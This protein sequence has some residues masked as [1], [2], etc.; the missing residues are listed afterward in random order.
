MGIFQNLIISASSFQTNMESQSQMRQE[1]IQSLNPYEYHHE[2]SDS[3]ERG[4]IKQEFHDKIFHACVNDIKEEKDDENYY[5]NS[6]YPYQELETNPLE[7]ETNG[8]K[9][10]RESSDLIPKSEIKSEEFDDYEDYGND[11]AY[12]F[13]QENY[14]KGYEITKPFICAIC[15]ARFTAK[16]SLNT[17]MASVHEGKKHYCD[18][19]GANFNHRQSLKGHIASVHEG[20]KPFICMVCQK[21]FAAGKSLRYHMAAFHEGGVKKPHKCSWCAIAFH[22]KYKLSEHIDSVHEGKRPFQCDKC[23]KS[24]SRKSVLRIHEASVHDG[25]K[26]FSCDSCGAAFAVNSKLT[27][28]ICTV[29]ERISGDSEEQL[30][31]GKLHKKKGYSNVKLVKQDFL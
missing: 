18:L 4:I 28:H 26:P 7:L 17:H 25:E 3:D 21:T 27:R 30:I 24:F 10:E 6:E 14:E 23:E 2:E 1:M 19:C 12:P 9:D 29:H 11:E 22:S 20:N 16:T 8:I 13:N 15:N 31:K 5:D